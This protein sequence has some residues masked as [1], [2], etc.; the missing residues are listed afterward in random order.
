MAASLRH[1]KH[2]LPVLGALARTA[3]QSLRGA[4][5]TGTPLVGQRLVD[6][7][8]PPPQDLVDDYIR[9]VGGSHASWQGQLPPHL[10]PQ[11]GFPLMSRTLANV[12]Y[13]LS[14]VL[15]GGCR[16]EVHHPLPAQERLH[17]EAS[18]VDIDD[19]G[20][21]AVL[22]QRLTTGLIGQA[23]AVTAHV[24]AIVPYKRRE[25][26]RKPKPEV[27]E[28]STASEAWQL[29]ARAGLDFAILTGD[30]NPIHW[31]PLAGRAAGFGGCILHGFAT[32]ARTWEGIARYA[33]SGDPTQLATLDARFV[34]PLKLPGTAELHVGPADAEA[35]TVHVGPSPGSRAIM[36]ASYTLKES[37]P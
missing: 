16:I 10:F 15:N 26:P 7:V 35:H 9:A 30:F 36:T 2:Q 33:S 20:Y 1:L 32:L 14:K 28:T 4:R 17:L 6:E 31:I 27:P 25:G 12:P 18:L 22:H 37:S 8:D 3:V 29:D 19:D 5:T 21:R 23:P 24:Y 11:W 34:S 13:D